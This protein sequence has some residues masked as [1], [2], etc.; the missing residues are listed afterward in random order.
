MRCV[1]LAPGTAGG[2]AEDV[3]AGESQKRDSPPLACPGDAVGEFGQQGQAVGGRHRLRLFEVDGIE[4]N[5][6]GPVDD[7]PRRMLLAQT[8]DLRLYHILRQRQAARNVSQPAQVAL[9]AKDAPQSSALFDNEDRLSCRGC[10]RGAR[11]RTGRRCADGWKLE[12]DG[13]VPPAWGA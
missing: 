3:R 2:L 4:N 13:T 9:G 10:V 8:F 11:A 12:A 5:F 6:G 7:R 1:R